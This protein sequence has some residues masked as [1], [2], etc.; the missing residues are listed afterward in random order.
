MSRLVDVITVREV[1]ASRAPSSSAPGPSL[2]REASMEEISSEGI[3]VDQELSVPHVT[4][5]Y[6]YPQEST[7]PF[8]TNRNTLSY[9]I[10]TASIPSNK[11][12]APN[13]PPFESAG[14]TQSDVPTSGE[15][16][17]ISADTLSRELFGPVSDSADVRPWNDLVTQ[18]WQDLT[19]KGLPA[20]QRDTLLKKY[21]PSDELAF[22]R[23]PK[24]NPECKSAL[25]NNVVAK[26]DEYNRINQDQLGTALFAFGEAFSDLL[27]PEIQGTLTPEVRRAVTTFSEGTKILADLFYR[28]SIARRSSIRSTFNFLARSTADATS[29]GEFLFGSSFG[30]EIKKATSMEKASKDIMNTTLTIPRRV[31]Q[32]IKAPARPTSSRS[33]NFRAPVS[34]SRSAPTKRTGASSSSRRSSYHQRSHSRRR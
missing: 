24:L 2:S 20:D 8:P 5:V 28:L 3:Y 7:Q 23:A 6:E 27:K 12:S 25:K 15:L 31:Q 29:A 34:R 4:G 1:R 11:G 9:P 22:L 14:L 21:S 10:A 13:S 17:G 32:P 26:K 19:L 16:D 33:E 18:N 30:E